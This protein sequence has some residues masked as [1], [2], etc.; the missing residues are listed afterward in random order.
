VTAGR[1]GRID[2]LTRACATLP[3]AATWVALALAPAFAVPQAYRLFEEN[4]V[5]LTRILV[6]PAFAVALALRAR[7]KP[8]GI[9]GI[10]LA[11]WLGA[12]LVAA[13]ASTS[14]ALA[15][16]GDYLRQDGW[17]TDVALAG[18]FLGAFAGGRDR[19]MR[20]LTLDLILAAGVVSAFVAVLGYTPWRPFFVDVA[21]TRASGL[22][23]GPTYFGTAMAAL[24]PLALAQRERRGFGA[25][26]LLAFLSV[27]A[28]GSRLA[29]LAAALG[30]AYV[31]LQE[32]RERRARP[33]LVGGLLV[34]AIGALSLSP[35]KSALPPDLLPTR[36]ADLT[37]PSE[38]G[39]RVDLYAE[40]IAAIVEHPA[41]LA[42]GH[43]PDTIGVEFTRWI[44]EALQTAVGATTRVD[45]F[46]SELLD[47][48]FTRGVFA[49]LGLIVLVVGAWRA[50]RKS[51][52]DATERA[53]RG[54]VLVLTLLALASVAGVA[55]KLTWFVALG[56]L[57]QRER[58]SDTQLARWIAPALVGGVVAAAMVATHSSNVVIALVPLAW[59]VPR[60]DLVALLAGVAPGALVAL[61]WEIA[62][63]GIDPSLI[64]FYG[65]Q[66]ANAAILA[67]G[68]FVALAG[69]LVGA[70]AAALR[71]SEPAPPR[72]RAIAAGVLWLAALFVARDDVL[73][74]VA[75]LRAGVAGVTQARAGKPELAARL[76]ADA[77][78][79]APEVAQYRISRALALVDVAVGAD[80][81]QRLAL[82][83]MIGEEIGRARLVHAGDGYA[84]AVSALCVLQL[85]SL[86]PAHREALLTLADGLVDEA[87]A[88]AP[89]AAPVLEIAA[90]ARLARQRTAEA[91]ELAD[92][93]LRLDASRPGA[94]LARARASAQA[95]E[96]ESAAIHYAQALVQGGGA[97]EARAAL[98]Y[99]AMARE[100]PRDAGAL[101]A[102]IVLAVDQGAPLDV[103][104]ARPLLHFVAWHHF[105]EAFAEATRLL[106][107]R[108]ETIREVQAAMTY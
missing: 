103:E 18:A 20:G 88:R 27:L 61:S 7:W 92:H 15:L 66:G 2:A 30:A 82:V 42:S 33:L 105:S 28:S 86:I 3:V 85:A 31:L 37:R 98:A 68:A 58:T 19:G 70:T 65:E 59:I 39:T 62:G 9:A 108:R 63:P 56:L 94:H 107:D 32:P 26:A 48:V 57:A 16:P 106:P 4:K 91:A 71:T 52:A 72:G 41:R 101:I 64:S 51:A 102:A 96:L 36:L 11:T 47:V 34:L 1:A 17:L 6:V 49:A 43:G 55:A 100:Q 83:P 81:A 75:D 80:D 93:A 38:L 5:L 35:W 23:G 69:V 44:S 79:L 29:L 25:F 50:G 40:A 90:R 74:V 95:R 21:S 14:P 84:R 13:L 45:R 77:I 76:L 10:G 78:E 8:L 99:T 46:H 54:L 73:R 67:F 89:Q 104:G 22:A 87:L 97:V 60:R 53:L 12:S 24:V